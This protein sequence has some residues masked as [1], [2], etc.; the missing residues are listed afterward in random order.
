MREISA[1][2]VKYT[3]SKRDRMERNSVKK[4]AFFYFNYNYKKK[5]RNDPEN[6][7]EEL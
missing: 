3:V 6:L 5:Y 4:I 2:R 7:F 1:K